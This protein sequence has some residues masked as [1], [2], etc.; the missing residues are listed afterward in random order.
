MSTLQP[1]F[2]ARWTRLSIAGQ[3]CTTCKTPPPPERS[4][5]RCTRCKRAY[6][7]S[8]DCARAHFPHHKKLCRIL[9][10]LLFNYIDEQPCEDLAEWNRRVADRMVQLSN[11]LERRLDYQEQNLMLFEPRCHV[12]FVTALALELEISQD[13]VNPRTLIPCPKCR[14]IAC[15]S[16]AHWDSY[17]SRHDTVCDKYVLSVSCDNLL[18]KHDDIRWMQKEYVPVDGPGSYPPLPTGGWPSYFSWRQFPEVLSD[19]EETATAYR[20]LLTDR[21]SQ[22]LTILSALQLAQEPSALRALPTLTIHLAG[23][24][25]H[26]ILASWATEEIMHCIPALQSLHTVLIDPTLD[27]KPIINLSLAV[28]PTCT[29]RSRSRIFSTHAL[30]Y[31][32][33]VSSPHYTRPDLVVC[34]NSGLHEVDGEQW[35]PTLRHIVDSGIPCAFTSYNKKEVAE[36]AAVLRELGARIVCGPKRN[37]WGS[38]VP[39]VEP[40]GVDV[41]YGNST[42]WFVVMGQK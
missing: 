30:T 19:P 38:E 23:A 16:E 10:A 1:S 25:Q 35:R 15:C 22:P 7:C 9:A 26:E 11:H 36:D 41:F 2:P 18:F 29:T 20:T 28:C 4:L 31:H 42:W 17:R 39:L 5:L 6:Y 24:S 12:C 34:F 32:D 40:M 13:N 33:F 21:L 3:A 27:S 8:E 37:E 14:I